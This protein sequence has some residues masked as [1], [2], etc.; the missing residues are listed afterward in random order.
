MAN[1]EDGIIASQIEGLESRVLSIVTAWL[2]GLVFA[3][4]DGV[5]GWIVA[6]RE[7]LLGALSGGGAAVLGAFATV[8]DV[9]IELFDLLETTFADLASL[10]GPFAPLVVLL[11][12]AFVALAVIGL[13]RIVLWALPLVIPWL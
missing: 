11:M 2:V 10:A 3:F 8:G 9:P 5:T 13:I 4:R 12:W 7:A 1:G 6:A